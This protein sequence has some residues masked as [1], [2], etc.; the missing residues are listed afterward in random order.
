MLELTVIARATAKLGKEADL[1]RAWK[2][3]V[4]EAMKE[5]GCRSY[6]L[7]RSVENPLE[8]YSIERWA[9]QRA[10]DTHMKS[11]SVARLMAQVPD[12]VN[13]QPEIKV[14]NQVD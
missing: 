10:F 5:Q 2:S 7:F 8:F 4:Q 11:A 9:S 12:L 13:G 3:V 6:T 1:E 14:L